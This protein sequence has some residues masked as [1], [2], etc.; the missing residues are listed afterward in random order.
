MGSFA[1]KWLFLL[2]VS[3]FCPKTIKIP[4]ELLGFG[5]PGRQGPQKSKMCR[6]SE[7]SQ[8]YLKLAQNTVS[9]QIRGIGPSDYRLRCS[10][11]VKRDTSEMHFLRKF[12]K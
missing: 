10:C 9:R 12:E 7:F 1:P 2:K 6:K 8:K 5:A 11:V 3:Y 4:W